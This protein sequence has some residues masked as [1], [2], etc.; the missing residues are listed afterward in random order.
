MRH[1]KRFVR[2]CVGLLVLCVLQAACS[3][4]GAQDRLV[5]VS[6]GEVVGHVIAQYDERKVNVDYRVDSNGR[7]PK[8]R[9]NLELDSRGFPLTWSIAGSSLFGAEVDETYAW[10]RGQAN[11]SSQADRGSASVETPPLYVGNDSSPWSLGLYARAL[12]DAPEQTLEILPAGHLGIQELHRTTVGDEALPIGIYSLSGIWLTPQMIAL[13]ESRRLF[14]SIG[15]RSVVIREGYES[16]AEV[17]RELSRQL[18]NDRIR[19]L[20]REL[21]HEY[22]RPVRINNVYVFDPSIPGRSELKSVV[23]EDGLI[24]AVESPVTDVPS[25]NEV[26]VDGEGGTLVAGLFDMH[27][28]NSLDSGLFY[29]ASGVTSTRDMG[30]DIALLEELSTG[31]ESG[32]LPGPRMTRAGLIE[33]RSPYSA[34]IGIVAESLDDALQAVRWYADNGYYEIKT[35]NSMKPE[36]VAPVVAEARKA[37]LGVTGHVPAFTSPDTVIEAG[38]NSIAHINQLMLGW[39]L[40][41]GEDT[42]TPLRLTGMK[43]AVDLDVQS[44]RVQHTLSLMREYGTAQDT[45]AI[46]LE[47]LMKSRAGEIQPGDLPYLDHMPI[48]YQRYRKRTFVPLDEEGDDA[49]YDEAFDSLLAVIQELHRNGIQLLVGTDDATGFSVH[50][51]LEL[52][53]EAGISPSETLAL[54]T[55]GSAQYLQLADRVGSIEPGKYADFLLVP[56]DPTTD[57]SAIRQIRLVASRGVIYFPFDIYNAINIRPFASRPAVHVPEGAA[58]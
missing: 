19:V 2:H 1:G 26:I 18:E 24:S 53:V 56:G 40:E 12:L 6:N 20:Q 16:A 8:I 51:E 9:E 47:R 5:V 39:L 41:P 27:A 36:W 49:A 15:G 44:E 37:G 32:E 50:R 17:L 52:Y 7:G 21:G 45:T 43:R 10:D 29:L 54:A 25:M 22:D 48:G 11:W 42:R 28:H 14:A 46:I 34:R 13:D 23:V 58:L 31:V 35:Y 4:P 38:Y 57:I 55:L 30:N 33:A 3:R